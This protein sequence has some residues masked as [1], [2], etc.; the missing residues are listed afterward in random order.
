M[1]CTFTNNI[2]TPYL[3]YILKKI[4]KEHSWKIKHYLYFEIILSNFIFLSNSMIF[5]NTIK[6]KGYFWHKNKC[7]H[8]LT[9]PHSFIF[10][11]RYL[12]LAFAMLED[13][14]IQTIWWNILSDIFFSL[15][16]QFVNSI[17][18]ITG[19]LNWF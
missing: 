15:L 3:V 19:H 9:P 14:S 13:L 12:V 7:F 5:I 1:Y 16:T 11:E 8:P 4:Y 17:D 10:S 18:I 2:N 6:I